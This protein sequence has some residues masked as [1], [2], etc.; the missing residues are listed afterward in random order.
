[1]GAVSVEAGKLSGAEEDAGEHG[2][3]EPSGQGVA[4]RGM[5]AGEQAEAVG[6]LVLGAVGEGVGRAAGDD[7]GEYKLGEVAVPGDLAQA[8]DDTDFGQR[9]ELLRE[10]RAAVADLLRGGLVAGRGAADDG[11]NPSLAQSQA[12]VA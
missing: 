9:G 7:P 5:V 4:Q 2:A 6:E 8:D 1:M 12:V 11:G 10:M 3:V